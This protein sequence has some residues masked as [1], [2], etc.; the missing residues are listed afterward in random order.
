MDD[1]GRVTVERAQR[2]VRG[3]FM[4]AQGRQYAQVTFIDAAVRL[5]REDGL[6]VD[7]AAMGQPA[8]RDRMSRR[9]LPPG[10]VA[11]APELVQKQ[12]RF[13]WQ[14]FLWIGRYV[15]ERSAALLPSHDDV[16][17]FITAIGGEDYMSSFIEEEVAAVKLMTDRYRT[18]DP[19]A[20]MGLDE[21]LVRF[22]VP[23]F[24][25]A[26]RH[27]VSEPDRRRPGTIVGDGESMM[28]H[29][30]ARSTERRGR[31]WALTDLE[32][33][34]LRIASL[35]GELQ[36]RDPDLTCVP[37]YR[38]LVVEYNKRNPSAAVSGLH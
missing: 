31:G 3:T 36:D 2:M 8:A 26:D 24:V 15:F 23:A 10:H 22:T 32:R 20:A 4:A 25:R 17:A 1:E 6:A 18:V 9:S 29:L 12:F 35:L 7:W 13:W 14:Y 38:K 33:V 30:L 19:E 34:H 27:W 37:T 21:A 5:W 28:R 11:V 16:D